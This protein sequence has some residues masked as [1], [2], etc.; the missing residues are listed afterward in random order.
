MSE[1][2]SFIANTMNCEPPEFITSTKFA[3]FGAKK[4]L[5][6]IEFADG[7]GGVCGDHRT[8]ERYVWQS[9][10]KPVSRE[11]MIAANLLAKKARDEEYAK[12]AK[13]A[14]D[15]LEKAKDA[16]PNHPY[17]LTKKIKPHGLKQIG[18][19]L[20]VPVKSVS[21]VIQSIQEIDD[22][23]K[24]KF[25]AGGK[26]TGG[27]HMIGQINE[28]DP[29]VICEGM[30]TGASLFEDGCP[31]VVVAFSAWNL[32]PVAL[33]IRKHYPKVNIVIAGDDDW[34]TDGNPGQTAAIEAA[35]AVGGKCVI[36]NF[37]EHREPSWTDFN[38]LFTK[39]LHE[40]I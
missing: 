37:G 30:A 17:L 32:K 19:R 23:G 40:P 12:T 5:W 4:V 10:Q 36:P 25:R 28:D 1:F 13:H 14:Q 9:G 24:K 22:Q 21:G 20:L 39:A 11:S 33:E 8:G 2:K 34:Q 38:D 26:V 3:R 31:F 27:C 6:A 18:N 35:S 7:S 15:E 29:V 16:D